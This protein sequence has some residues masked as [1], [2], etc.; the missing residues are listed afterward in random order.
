M[1]ESPEKA[2]RFANRQKARVHQPI[3]ELIKTRSNP[4]SIEP[5]KIAQGTV[6]VHR[7]MQEGR[8]DAC[9]TILS[10]RL[11]SAEKHLPPS[12]QFD[13]INRIAIG[14]ASAMRRPL[15]RP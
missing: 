6:V 12:S 7:H 11:S 1:T 9:L 15:P 10:A 2:C 3:Q 13:T 5:E 4:T 14:G 8:R